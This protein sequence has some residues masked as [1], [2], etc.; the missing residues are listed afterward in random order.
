V[1]WDRHL[2][3]EGNHHHIWRR[4]WC[5]PLAGAPV[6]WPGVQVSP[7]GTQRAQLAAAR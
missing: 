7:L 6:V 5:P 1:N 4:L 3:A 2:F